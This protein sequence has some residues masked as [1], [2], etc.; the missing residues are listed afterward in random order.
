MATPH[1]IEVLHTPKECLSALDEIKAQGKEALNQWN[2]GCMAGEHVSYL[3]T[4]ANSESEALSKVPPS[5]RPK[6]KVHK[7]NK[8][9]VEQIESF[10]Q[11]K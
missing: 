4:Q 1:L 8:F 10:H 3:L 7:L 9:T 11:S 5:E 2:F 6:A